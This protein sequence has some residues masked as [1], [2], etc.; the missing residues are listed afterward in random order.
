ME[1]IYYIVDFYDYEKYPMICEQDALGLARTY[2]LF[3]YCPGTM[4]WKSG[5]EHVIT[6]D[7]E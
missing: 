1:F 2:E 5:Q 4:S 3:G 7:E 6:L